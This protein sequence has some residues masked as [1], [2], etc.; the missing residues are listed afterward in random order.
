MRAER[1]HTKATR[2]LRARW[3]ALVVLLALAGGVAYVVT[4]LGGSEPTAPPSLDGT[5]PASSSEGAGDQPLRGDA[6]AL[7]RTDEPAARAGL[8]AEGQV[9]ALDLEAAPS[10]H[11]GSRDAL[12]AL[13]AAPVV[14]FLGDGREEISFS[15]ALAVGRDG[16]EQV[17]L[18]GD[19]RL[20]A[21]ALGRAHVRSSPGSVSI[22]A[23]QLPPAGSWFVAARSVDPDG[24][25]LE[26]ASQP[27]VREG[28]A[29]TR[30]VL[31]APAAARGGLVARVR[32]GTEVLAECAVTVS[33]ISGL[34]LGRFRFAGDAPEPALLPVDRLLRVRVSDARGMKSAGAPP[35]QEVTLSFGRTTELVFD[36]PAVAA[37]S[38]RGTT[39]RGEAV[40]GDLMIWSLDEHGHP[41]GSVPVTDAL[42]LRGAAG[43]A[44]RLP[45][46]RYRGIFVPRTE[47]SRQVFDV[48]VG[49]EGAEVELD[50]GHA[51]GDALVELEVVDADG[52][53]LSDHRLTFVREASAPDDVD[54]AHVRTDPRGAAVLRPLAPGRWQVLDYKRGLARVVDLPAGRSDLRLQL[55]SAATTGGERLE[56]RALA[57]SG[58]PRPLLNVHVRTSGAVWWRL[59]SA[60]VEA[61]AVFEGLEPGSYEVRVPPEWSRYADVGAGH[62]TVLV[63]EGAGTT[64]LDVRLPRP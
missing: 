51:D 55:P 58:E 29:R 44:G 24:R 13:L 8:R 10:A 7:R 4:T 34:P 11:G 41:Q 6:P 16:V 25:V 40:P 32:R 33:E 15:L 61:A 19:G 42:E 3:T 38:V 36:L 26:A 20:A 43:W 57:A 17:Q 37:F 53:P 56:I 59:A 12:H 60:G 27:V 50:L 30:L 18:E 35:P 48:D 28:D 46:G 21:R 64:R 49:E 14:V 52:E 1:T 31:A 54:W 62:A 5:A 39:P 23:I 47:W 22:E 9:V 2:E 63:Q 45:P